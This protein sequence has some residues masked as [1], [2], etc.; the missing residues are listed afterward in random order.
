MRGVGVDGDIVFRRVVTN[1]RT[2]TRVER[3]IVRIAHPFKEFVAHVSVHRIVAEHQRQVRE[4]LVGKQMVPSCCSRGV[5]PEKPDFITVVL[6]ETVVLRFGEMELVA[7]EIGAEVELVLFAEV[8]VELGVEVEEIVAHRHTVADEFHDGYHQE[9]EVGGTSRE[10]ERGLVFLH[11]AL[12]HHVRG[13]QSDAAFAVV[14]LLVAVLHID[15]D[16]GGEPSP[17]TGRESAF[18]ELHR[19]DGVA[20]ED[21]EETQQVAGVVDGGLVKEDKVLV[22]AAAAHVEAGIAF[23]ARLHARQQLDGLDDVGLTHKRGQ[24]LDGLDAHFHAP[25]VA[26][27]HIHVAFLALDHHLFALDGHRLELET[28]GQVFI[29]HQRVLYRLV[30]HEV[31]GQFVFSRQYRHGIV[32]RLVG[33]ASLHVGGVRQIGED[34][35]NAHHGFSVGGVRHSA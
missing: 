13:D 18:H 14:F 9:V 34:D 11:R 32:T 8:E 7:T 10:H 17:V 5:L 27:G 24:R 16:D 29:Q 3:L 4:Y 6:P 28:L 31:D 25:H 23:A 26:A 30:S 33:D 22:G 15:V 35:V 20:V 2:E 12:H 19:L 21:G 1:A